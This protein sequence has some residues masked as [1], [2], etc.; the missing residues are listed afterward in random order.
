MC[1]ITAHSWY[2][3][4]L[5]CICCC[6]N[7]IGK[8]FEYF[9]INSDPELMLTKFSIKRNFN[10]NH[11]YCHFIKSKVLLQ[12]VGYFLNLNLKLFKSMSVNREC[13]VFVSI[14]MFIS[15]ITRNHSAQF[16]PSHYQKTTSTYQFK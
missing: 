10:G 15:D 9:Q 12:S 2:K 8:S 7:P 5:W 1:C 14:C 6:V 16:H 4:Q 3:A 13:A 11:T